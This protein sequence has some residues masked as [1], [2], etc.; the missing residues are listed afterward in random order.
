MNVAGAIHTAGSRPFKDF[1]WGETLVTILNS[2]LAGDNVVTSD[3]T[4]KKV[5]ELLDA[6]P[7]REKNLILSHMVVEFDE[8]GDI[9][10]PD[11]KLN[12]NP[13]LMV[14]I[15]FCLTLVVISGVMTYKHVTSATDPTTMN[16]LITVIVDIIKT[17]LSAK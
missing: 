2:S 1:S 10:S 9:K 15:C 12:I 7:V 16:T 11:D 5:I 17:A 8:D 4:G 14:L 6:L 13:K 3:S